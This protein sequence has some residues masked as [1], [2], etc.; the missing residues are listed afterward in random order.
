MSFHRRRLQCRADDGIEETPNDEVSVAAAAAAAP[1]RS[2]AV[3]LD[4]PEHQQLKAQSKDNSCI[5]QRT[6]TTQSCIHSRH[7]DAL[8][9]YLHAVRRRGTCQVSMPTA[10]GKLAISCSL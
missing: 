9:I 4:W 7:T 8:Q 2:T 3:A 6:F 1:D 10:V 5:K